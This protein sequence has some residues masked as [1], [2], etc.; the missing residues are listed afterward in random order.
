MAAPKA[1]LYQSHELAFRTQYAELKERTRAMTSL[2]PGTP[3]TLVKRTGTGRAYWYRV[4]K[5]ASGGQVEDLIGREDD[6]QKLLDAR[7]DLEFAQ[8]AVSQV[9]NLRKLEF[10]VA[11]K[12]VASVLVELHNRGLLADGLVVVGTL[13]YMA[14]L[15]ELGARAVSAR[16]QDIDL[17]AR[18]RLKLAAPQSFLET[19]QG[20]RLSFTPVPGMPNAEPPTSLKLPGRD[21]LRVDVLIHGKRLGE[22]VPVAP[23]MWHAQT[24]PHYDYLLD[25]P[26]QAAVLAGGHCIPVLMPQPERLVWHKLYASASRQSFPEKAEKDV[27]Q[28]VTLAAILTDQDDEA[29]ADSV[30]ELPASMRGTLRRRLPAVRRALAGHERA[31]AAFELA[32]S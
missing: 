21:G 6:E 12:G 25:Q 11:D 19:I 31:K 13:A 20:T 29:L 32:L 22:S 8:W 18:Q 7:A 15:N 4:Y 2:L 27:L 5:D 28:A 1:L 30:A 14:W 3:G 17:A 10:Q 26:R 9:R 24:V 23:L 16:T